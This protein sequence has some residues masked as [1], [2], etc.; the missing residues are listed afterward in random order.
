MTAEEACQMT[1]EANI[2]FLGTKG[3]TEGTQSTQSNSGRHNS[4][5]E[6]LD[7]IFDESPTAT[8]VEMRS[9]RRTRKC[10]LLTRL[11][12]EATRRGWTATFDNAV[13][14]PLRRIPRVFR[15]LSTTCSP[16][17]T[18]F[19]SR[20]S[21]PSA[22]MDRDPFPRTP[23]PLGR[24]GAFRS[25]RALPA[26]QG[27]ALCPSP[28][29]FTTEDAPALD[30]GRSARG[31]NPHPS[32]SPCEPVPIRPAVPV[33]SCRSAAAVVARPEALALPRS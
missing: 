11:C 28:A 18:T 32:S 9:D 13:T 24:Y 23:E 6:Q 31:L 4:P 8:A 7:R 27:R 5:T 16:S 33:R 29:R 3:T 15:G 20:S 14:Q 22:P 26:A 10:A 12:D 17:A 30:T 25:V 19:R 2:A 21:P 1:I